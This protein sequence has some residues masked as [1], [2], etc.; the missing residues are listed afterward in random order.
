MTESIKQRRVVVTGGS[1]F[2]GR[3][4]L[5]R[6]MDDGF[7]NILNIDRHVSEG[8]ITSVVSDFAD[9]NLLRETL[10][11]GDVVIHLACTTIPAS[12]EVDKE[13]DIQENV[14]GTLRLLE[15]CR[16]KEVDK[17]IFFSS[18]GT[19][20]GDYGNRPIPESACARPNSA[21]GIMKL[22]IEN[23][24]RLYQD[25]YGL[26]YLIIRAANPYGRFDNYSKPQGAID[27]FLKKALSGETI[28]IWGDGE[29]VRDY[30]HIDDLIGLIHAA[31]AGDVRNE[32]I[33]AGTGSGTSLNRALD[34]IKKSVHAEVR[35]NYQPSRGFDVQS[36][37]LDITKAKA[38]LD[39]QPKIS[40]EEGI[41]LMLGKLS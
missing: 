8:A 18:G 12:S 16:E 9:M 39:W 1:G 19:V 36:N 6:L 34:I 17:V 7:E 23:Y 33:N 28:E 40:L 13:R 22:T 2:I 37:I 35:I 24:L 27:I 41:L 3:N 32:I 20:Y 25:K 21:H 5:A 38:L 11:P 10:Q 4:L 15:V 29:A 31:L 30:I 14:I 26:D